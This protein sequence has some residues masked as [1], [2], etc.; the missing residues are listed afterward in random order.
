MG[1]VTQHLP[2]DA[3]L[4]VGSQL[5]QVVI[6]GQGRVIRLALD[7]AIGDLGGLGQL[8][9]QGGHFAAGADARQ[10]QEFVGKVAD[11]F[12][13]G[14]IRLQLRVQHRDF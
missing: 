14:R 4:G 12:G 9:L 8:A 11:Q 1:Q 2:G 5:E 10:L 7:E 13:G 6:S 3:G